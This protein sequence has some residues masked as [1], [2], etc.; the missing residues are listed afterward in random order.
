MKFDIKLIGKRISTARKSKNLKQSDLCEALHI[1][2][3]TLSKIENGNYSNL[4][5]E[6]INEFSDLLDVSVAWLTG[7][8]ID[9]E[10]TQEE[11]FALNEY[12][13][14]LKYKRNKV[15]IK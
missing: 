3:S 14:F 6:M 11:N 12:K 7:L 2:Q 9:A 8:D 4:T 10:L 1:S 13:E 15:K 5:L